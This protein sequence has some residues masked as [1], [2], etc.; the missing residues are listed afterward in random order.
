MLG[1]YPKTGGAKH[2][3]N[4]PA[5]KDSPREKAW[6]SVPFQK[7]ERPQSSGCPPPQRPREAC[8]V[9]FPVFEENEVNR[10]R[11]FAA[12]K[13][14]HVAFLCIQRKKEAF[15]ALLPHYPQL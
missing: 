1:V 11:P 5:Q 14:T 13:A 2:E 10:Q 9:I 7:R 12:R 4:V 3:K 8:C 6:L 15:Y